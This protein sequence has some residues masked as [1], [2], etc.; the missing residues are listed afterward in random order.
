MAAFLFSTVE[1]W[2]PE[3]M[4]VIIILLHFGCD[5]MFSYRAVKSNYGNLR[6]LNIIHEQNIS[7]EDLTHHGMIFLNGREVNEIDL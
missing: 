2:H 5:S 4:L 6:F 7:Q 3:A 1:N